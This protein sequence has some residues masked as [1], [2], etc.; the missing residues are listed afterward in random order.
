MSAS[1]RPLADAD[2]EPV[3]EGK[4]SKAKASSRT[5]FEFHILR[6]RWPGSTKEDVAKNALVQAINRVMDRGH[7][8]GAAS[9]LD[10]VYGVVTMDAFMDGKGGEDQFVVEVLL[11]FDNDGRAPFSVERS[12]VTD[13]LRT[14]QAHLKAA[15][16]TSHAQ[17]VGHYMD[18]QDR[19]LCNHSDAG[20]HG[21]VIQK[22]PDMFLCTVA[23]PRPM[24]MHM[25]PPA[26]QPTTSATTAAGALLC[27]CAESDSKIL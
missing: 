14:Q 24:L 2:E 5:D 8:G 27:L 19:K 3:Q 21:V 6:A 18:M 26:P 4:K 23:T 20:I 9:V 12:L 25:G 10:A 16:I 1:K 11:H 17:C 13:E 7:A 22:N 15:G